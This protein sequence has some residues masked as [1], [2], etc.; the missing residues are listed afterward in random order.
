M[1]LSKE[2]TEWHLTPRGWE[3]GS[4][5]VDFAGTTQRLPPADRVLTVRN[6]ETQSSMY[7]RMERSTSTIWISDDKTLLG[8]LTAKYGEAPLG[9]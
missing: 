2:W 3:V 8:E 5:R 9:L 4:E 1:A 6:S 7:S